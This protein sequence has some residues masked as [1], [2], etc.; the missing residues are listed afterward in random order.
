M[1]AMRHELNSDQFAQP[2]HTGIPVRAFMPSKAAVSVALYL[3]FTACVE[4]DVPEPRH[5]Y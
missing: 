2:L 5:V 3:F 4:L 1:R